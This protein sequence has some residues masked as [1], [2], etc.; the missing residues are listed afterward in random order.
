[1]FTD[2]S[3]DKFYDSAIES[4]WFEIVYEDHDCTILKIREMKGEPP[5]EEPQPSTEPGGNIIP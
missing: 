3:H 4:G 1:V 2:N 5:P